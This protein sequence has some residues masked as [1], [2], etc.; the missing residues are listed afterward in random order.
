VLGQCGGVRAFLARRR[1][2]SPPR[3]SLLPPDCSPSNNTVKGFANRPSASVRKGNF[4]L[5]DAE[6]RPTLD[7]VVAW[8]GSATKGLMLKFQCSPVV[9]HTLALNWSFVKQVMEY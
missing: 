6:K 3:R 7:S 1:P 8:R 4:S 9:L 5:A 2:G